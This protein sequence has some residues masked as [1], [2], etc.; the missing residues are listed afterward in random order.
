MK[1]LAIATLIILAVV[2]N[3]AFAFQNEPD[4]FRDLKW[5]DPPTG[6]MRYQLSIQGD[7]I[8]NR[9]DDKMQLGNVKLTTINYFFY[10]GRFYVVDLWFDGKENYDLVKTLC[11][12]MFGE[13][14]SEEGLYKFT[15]GGEKACVFLSWNPVKK[16]GYLD[17]GSSDIWLEKSEAKK[18]REVIKQEKRDYEAEIKVYVRKK[19]PD[20]YEMQVYE[21]NNQMK[22][23]NQIRNLPS[24][25]DYNESILLK[26]M[27]KWGKDYEMVIYEYNNQLE[28][29][30]KMR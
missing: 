23:L 19:W 30:K 1:K 28:A 4:G 9:A 3:T 25:T 13:T 27:T 29:Y 2:I 26:A 24:T 17:L 18:K 7:K 14:T 12:G 22:A 8:Y 21:Y 20:D 16:E 6:D 5:G 15:W 11:R 10:Q